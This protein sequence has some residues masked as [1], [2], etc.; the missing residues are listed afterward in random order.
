MP[1]RGPGQAA[2]GGVWP[3]RGAP[4]TLLLAPGVFLHYRI[5]VI[6]LDFSEHFH[7]W[8]FSAINRHN[9]QKLALWHLV[10]RLVP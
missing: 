5:S 3:P 2:P 1:R 10:N 7:F 8:T 9:K 4:P 6:F